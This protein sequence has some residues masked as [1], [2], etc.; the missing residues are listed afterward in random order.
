MAS[1]KNYNPRLRRL[2]L[3][4]VDNQLR[5]NDPPVTK[6]TYDRLVIS[7]YSAIK[8]KEMIA[9]VVLGH[10]YDAMKYNKPFDEAQYAKELRELG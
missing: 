2:I 10:I 4:V 8:A 9:A 1:N 6:E 3:E 5:D 7:G